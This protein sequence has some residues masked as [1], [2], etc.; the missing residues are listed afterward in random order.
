MDVE[1]NENTS[2]PIFSYSFCL[3]LPLISLF[4]LAK[5]MKNGKLVSIFHAKVNSL[6]KYAL[7]SNFEWNLD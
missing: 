1:T 7:F 6:I 3:A 4:D 5:E 2:K